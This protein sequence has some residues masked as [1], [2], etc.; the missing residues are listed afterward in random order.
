M[1]RLLLFSLIVAIFLNSCSNKNNEVQPKLQATPITIAGNI[2]STAIFGS[3]SWTLINY[4]GSGGLNYGDSVNNISKGKLYS[5][6]EAEAISLPKGWRIPTQDDYNKLVVSLGAVNNNGWYMVTT[7]IGYS[8]MA[9]T[10]WIGGEGTNSSSFDAVPVGCY[11]DGFY[12]SG[13]NAAFLTSSVINTWPGV[14]ACFFIELLGIGPSVG[15][16]DLP[17]MDVT[18]TVRASI[19]FVKDN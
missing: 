15:V 16:G 5:I 17:S 1:K 7:T 2:Y 12:G 10:G 9:K 6:S 3:Q 13:T 4:N 11:V 8:L 19:R 14:P 18:P